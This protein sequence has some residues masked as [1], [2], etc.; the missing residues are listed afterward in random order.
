MQR[1]Q[2]KYKDPD[3]V[4]AYPVDWT[5]ELETGDAIATSVFTAITS[6][7]TI[8][9]DSNTDTAATAVISGGTAGEVYNIRNRITT[10]NG[11]TYDF[12]FQIE[13]RDS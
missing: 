5:Y 9:S 3:E 11:Y 8:D 4:R 13:V 10:D 12:T 6:G 1:Y 7:I 2:K